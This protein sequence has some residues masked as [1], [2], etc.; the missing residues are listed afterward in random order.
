MNP[1]VRD[2]D[3]LKAAIEAVAIALGELHALPGGMAVLIAAEQATGAIRALPPG[4][5]TA[6][7]TRLVYTIEECHRA[8]TAQSPRLKA[9]CHAV[10]CALQRDPRWT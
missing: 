5:T 2:D 8:N 6:A 9:D 7:L 10:A 3:E 1:D 4:R